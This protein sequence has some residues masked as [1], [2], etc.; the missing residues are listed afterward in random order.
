MGPKTGLD[1]LPLCQAAF[2]KSKV[3][4]GVINWVASLGWVPFNNVFGETAVHL[5]FNVPDWVCR[6]VIFLATMIASVVVR[7]A[8]HQFGKWMSYAP[9]VIFMNLS[10]K[11]LASGAVTQIP[12]TVSCHVSFGS[13]GY[14]RL[15]YHGASD[16]QSCYG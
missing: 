8:I 6:A 11:I 14:W 12:T 3:L 9:T 2:G 1:Q 4:L 15:G 13:R 16:G 10:V 7:E 5:L